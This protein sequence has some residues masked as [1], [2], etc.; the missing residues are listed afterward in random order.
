MTYGILGYWEK[1]VSVEKLKAKAQIKRYRIINQVLTI[2]AYVSLLLPVAQCQSEAHAEC[3]I[4]KP[5]RDL[6]NC[7]LL[8]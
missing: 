1:N 8:F 6:Q 4:V 7:R 3:R 5:G 2:R